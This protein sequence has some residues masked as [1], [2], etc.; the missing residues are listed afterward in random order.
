MTTLDLQQRSAINTIKQGN[1][2]VEKQLITHSRIQCVQTCRKKHWWKY[3]QGIRKQ[4]DATALRMGSIYHQMLDLLGQGQA[5]EIALEYLQR[6]Y[7]TNPPEQLD[8]YQAS[9][10]QATLAVL[11]TCYQWRWAHSEI[12]ILAT[13]KSFQI[14]L[15]N[16]K[17]GSASTVFDHAGKLDKSILLEDGRQGLME[18]KLL[19]VDHGDGSDLRKMLRMDPQI[20][21]YLH[22]ERVLGQLAETIIYDVTRKPTIKP[23]AIPVLDDDGFKIV[24]D[25]NGNRVFLADK[26]KK[27]GEITSGK[28]RQSA[29]K[30]NK[31]TL[32]T[33]PMTPE[34]WGEKLRSDIGERPDF[35]FSRIEVPR[36][37][38]EIEDAL[39]DLWDAQK[40]IR[41]AQNTGRWFRTVNRNSCPFCE[42]FSLCCAKYDL[43]DGVPEGFEHSDNV[44][45]EL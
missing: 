28:P 26:L 16:P 35:Y 31:W 7:V 23:S 18:H 38:D 4:S 21:L 12:T 25:Q 8:D 24:I 41:E 34:E 2:L 42:Y 17:T 15:C 43:A 10:E 9:I 19:G 6:E 11:V 27:N 33:R 29:S 1:G 37:D 13:E 40:T 39:Q 32:Y 22:A 36:L 30:D 14:P 44:H 3:E 45:P 5:L 20:T